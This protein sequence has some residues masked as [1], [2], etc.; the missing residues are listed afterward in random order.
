MADQPLRI[1]IVEDNEDDALLIARRFR[2]AGYD[3]AVTRVDCAKD[4]CAALRAADWDVIISD[5][6]MPR[7][8][9]AAALAL[10]LEFQC[11]C[12]FIVVS[13]AIGEETAV[14]LL[15]AGAHDFLLK[16]NLARLVPATER[17]LRETE[18]RRARH[19]AEEALRASEER[20]ALAAR[21]ANDGLWDWDL[22]TN[23]I[24]FSPRWAEMLGLPQNQP[25]DRPDVWFRRVHREDVAALRRSLDDHL[26]GRTPH[27]A[28]EYR[29]RHRDG[30]WRWM[31]TRGLAVV[32][33]A[34]VPCR[35]AG[36]QT[37][38]TAAKQAEQQLRRSKEDLEHAV[39]AK[40]RFLAS[41]SHDL[42]QPVQALVCFA[43]LLEL[44]LQDHPAAG[45]VTDLG[46]ALDSL[47][48]LLDALLDVSRLDAGV[49]TPE[50]TAFPV[51][52]V[53]DQVAT[54][55]RPLA[56]AKGLRLRI[57]ACSAVVRSDPVLLGRILRNLVENAIRYTHRGSILVGCRRTAPGL[58]IMVH[59]TGIGIGDDARDHI[60]EEFFQVANPERD[61]MKGLGLGLAIVA[62]LSR[63][64][65]HPVV[66]RS[67]PGRGSAF[68]VA[69]PTVADRPASR[70]S[71]PEE[72]RFDD[73]SGTILV[74]DDES[75]VASAL[76]GLLEAWGFEAV[77]AA[78]LEEAVAVVRQPPRAVLADY[79]LREGRTGLEA[80][81]ALRRFFAMPIPF[82]VVTGD[83]GADRLREIIESRSMVLHKPV[84][85]KDLRR[86]L[87]TVLSAA[88]GPESAR[89]CRDVLL[90]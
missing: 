45:T 66:V 33:P 11:D 49:V 46:N 82:I 28:V 34:G 5:V 29:I 87:Q 22:K 64:L 35:I 55:M 86:A 31:L 38:I 23:R 59:D 27:F 85:P 41:A 3:A 50:V 8:S 76:A 42:R 73:A 81:D 83:T 18:T 88:G 78:S 30:S 1:L 40:T 6:A 54:E 47:K 72:A 36:S 65:D 16:T 71:G 79:R 53:L 84:M 75:Q 69:V 62:R 77:I 44:Q 24:Y 67:T 20:Y 17:E 37:D 19:R 52:S 9:A 60:F 12:P 63:L 21:G 68:S 70:K 2:K 51:A 15:K 89:G 74:I 25:G 58:S 39:A 90:Q 32:D 13:G 7:F 61:R 26:G 57:A 4:M 56:E 14:S 10:Y 43:S 80:V 48:G